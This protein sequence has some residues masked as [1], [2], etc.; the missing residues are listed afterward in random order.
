MYFSIKK[1]INGNRFDVICG[2]LQ[3]YTENLILKWVKN[4]ISKTKYNNIC[5]AGGVAMNVK[6]N[7][8]LSKLKKINNV[9]IPPSR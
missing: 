4:C 9:Y 2:A 1:I 8:E 3:K 7:L 5:L 6:A